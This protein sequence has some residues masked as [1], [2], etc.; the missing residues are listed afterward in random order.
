MTRQLIAFFPF[1]GVKDLG[2]CL[3]NYLSS[4]GK[5]DPLLGLSSGHYRLDNGWICLN[6]KG[7]AENKKKGQHPP[8]M[9]LFHWIAPSILVGRAPSIDSD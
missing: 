1:P 4:G 5:R 6:L 3:D 8:D 2:G 7:K 9:F